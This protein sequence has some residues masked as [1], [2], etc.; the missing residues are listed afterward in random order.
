[1]TYGFIAYLFLS[2]VVGMTVVMQLFRANRTWAGII[3]L[4][5]FVLIFIFYGERWFRG[6]RVTGIYTGAWPP[7]INACPDYLVYYNR[8]GVDTCI[9]LLGVNRS[10]GVLRPWTQEDNAQNP[11]A[12]DAKYFLYTYKADMKPNEI[13]V[14]C[15]A[16]MSAGLTWEGITNGESCTYNPADRVLGGGGASEQKCPQPTA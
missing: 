4:I 7:I 1:M 12:D 10:N 2:I 9:D 13:Q 15:N 14:L 11:P 6:N 5:L 8:N 3:T 16:A